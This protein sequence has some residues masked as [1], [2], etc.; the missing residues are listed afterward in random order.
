MLK[1]TRKAQKS[2]DTNVGH[3]SKEEDEKLKRLIKDFGAKR[4]RIIASKMGTR[5]A[6]QCRERFCGHLEKSINKNPLSSFED[7]MV[8]RY[9]ESNHGWA[10]IAKLLGNNRT[11]NQIKNNYNQRLS[12]GSKPSSLNLS[13]QISRNVVCIDASISR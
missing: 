1:E 8:V 6:K 12:K 2:L 5:D 13:S 4:W 7:E 9:R 3:W 10:E 11:P